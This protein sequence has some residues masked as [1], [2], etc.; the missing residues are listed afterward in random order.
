[1]KRIS[2]IIIVPA[3][4]IVC[5]V[6]F[7]LKKPEKVLNVTVGVDNYP[8]FTF[9][10]EKTGKY[11]GFDIELL[12]Y[13]ART[14]NLKLKFVEV[15]FHS[16]IKDITTRKIDMADTMTI[17]PEREKKLDFSWPTKEMGLGIALSSS[18]KSVKR[19]ENLKGFEVASYPG[20]GE[21]LC[22][23]LL[24][25]KKIRSIKIYD[26]IDHMYKDLAE[27]KIK[28]VIND[29]ITNR[30]YEK[31]FPGKIKCLKQCYHYEYTGF[32]VRKGN[33]QLRTRINKGIK[34]AISSGKYLRLLRK[35]F[36]D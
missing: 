24:T 5:A 36:N 6:V 35:Y 30:N 27:G 19:L 34:K 23:E 1:M 10:N 25:Q 20:T 22:N 16:V 21:S 29:N 4:A 13:I 14:Q 2:L 26:S 18:C 17:L 11:T 9:Y 31:I 28:A 3:I 32:P 7:H 8:P 33:N 15:P 12:E